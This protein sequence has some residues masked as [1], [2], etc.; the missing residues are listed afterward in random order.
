MSKTDFSQAVFKNEKPGMEI[1]REKQGK[2][3]TK[4][5]FL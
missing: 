3:L 4:E 2:T 1:N 5:K